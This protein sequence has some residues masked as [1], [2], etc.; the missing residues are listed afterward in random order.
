MDEI[1]SYIILTNRKPP[2]ASSLAIHEQYIYTLIAD[3]LGGL[4]RLADI[5]DESILTF[6]LTTSAIKRLLDMGFIELVISEGN[7]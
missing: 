7:P 6:P 3:H 1:T 5:Y 2:K 4:S